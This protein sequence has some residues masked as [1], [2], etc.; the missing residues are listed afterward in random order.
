MNEI[1]S[2]LESNGFSISS[3]VQI[4]Q[5]NNYSKR[6]N[7]LQYFCIFLTADDLSFKVEDEIF[8]VRGGSAI[9]VGPQKVVELISKP[10]GKEFYVIA[11]TA[12]FFESSQ[13]D[14]L[15]LNSAIFFNNHS[16]IFTAPYFGNNDYNRIILIDRLQKFSNVDQSLFIAAAH[17]SIE[18]LLLDAH[19]HTNKNKSDTPVKTINFSFN[20][21]KVLLQKDFKKSKKVSYY[22]DLMFMSPRRLTEICEQVCN[23]SAKQIIIDK[24]KFE[25]EKEIKFTEL[26]FSEIG[27]KLGFND[28]GNFTNFVKKHLGKKPSEIRNTKVDCFFKV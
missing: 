16:P 20:K 5:R 19:F 10:D 11:F 26:S 6:F 25:C 17:N 21:F 7:T 18:S 23:K 15:L 2:Q 27:Y 28:E 12:A 13:K 9:F 24:I 3:L 14:S 8:N 1:A 22:A 4:I